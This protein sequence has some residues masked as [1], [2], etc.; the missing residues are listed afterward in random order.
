LPA[1]PAQG[2]KRNVTVK[3]ASRR[4]QDVTRTATTE[5]SEIAEPWFDWHNLV[6][7]AGLRNV[8]YRMQK[9]AT[10]VICVSVEGRS[11]RS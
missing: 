7:V 6:D 11:H 10:F 9:A 4:S 2:V 5:I 1:A 3:V 8:Y